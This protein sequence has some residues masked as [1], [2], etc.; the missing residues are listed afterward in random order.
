[1]K[2]CINYAA[3]IQL[4]PSFDSNK[5]MQKLKEELVSLLVK[6][7]MVATPLPSPY[8]SLAKSMFEQKTFE[9]VDSRGT[10]KFLTVKQ[11][12]ITTNSIQIP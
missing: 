3:S 2:F 1:M 6:D 8:S 11:N 12:T 4:L 7:N 5:E 9:T 10:K